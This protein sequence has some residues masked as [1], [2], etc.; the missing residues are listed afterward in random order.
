MIIEQGSDDV[1]DPQVHFRNRFYISRQKGIRFFVED[2]LEKAVKL[3]HICEVV[4][5]FDQ[6]YN[7]VEENKIVPSN[8]LRVRSWGEIYKEIRRLS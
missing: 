7:Q 2:H 4:F 1:S 5:L 3:A 8:I 6:P